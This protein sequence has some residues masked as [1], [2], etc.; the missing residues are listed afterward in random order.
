MFL[1]EVFAPIVYVLNLI[2]PCTKEYLLFIY[3][4][5]CDDSDIHNKKDVNNLIRTLLQ[6]ERS[7]FVNY[8]K[9]DLLY[10]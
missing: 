3:K 5:K 6:I 9:Y 4:K 1:C 8:V 10:K 7:T 2:A